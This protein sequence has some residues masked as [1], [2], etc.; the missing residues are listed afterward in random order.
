MI[1]KNIVR[2]MKS[3]GVS[4]RQLAEDTDMHEPDVSKLLRAA[5]PDG[6]DDYN[7]SI[8]SL[9]KIADALGVTVADLLTPR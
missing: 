7:F 6:E 8:P 2:L 9:A 3:Q 1:T 4:Q 5:K